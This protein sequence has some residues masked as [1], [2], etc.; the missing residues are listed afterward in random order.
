[1]MCK[2]MR[3]FSKSVCSTQREIP[4]EALWRQTHSPFRQT[5]I[6]VWWGLIELQHDKATPSAD[7]QWCL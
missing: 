4:R 7:F 5:S 6:L 1:L 3:R 2:S